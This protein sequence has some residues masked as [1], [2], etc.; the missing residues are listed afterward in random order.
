MRPIP[1]RLRLDLM[2]GLSEKRKLQRAVRCCRTAIFG[3]LL[4][5][6]VFAAPPPQPTF[7]LHDGELLDYVQRVLAASDET[8]AMREDLTLSQLSLQNEQQRFRTVVR[9]IANLAVDSSTRPRTGLEFSRHTRLGIDLSAGYATDGFGNGASARSFARLGI[10]L[11]QRFGRDINELPLTKAELQQRRRE[12]DYDR[13]LQHLIAD[14]VKNHIGLVLA[15]ELEQQAEYALSRAAKHT[16]AATARQRVGLISKVDVHRAEL[17]R[18]DREQAYELARYSSELKREE[19]AE[20]ARLQ[21]GSITPPENLP[22]L[23]LTPGPGFLPA[24]R[25]E[26]HIQRLDERSALLDLQASKRRMR[27]DL[28]LEVAWLG[29]DYGS[30]FESYARDQSDVYLSLRLDS[31][32]NFA[33][34][35]RAVA[36]QEIAYQRLRRN[37]RTLERRLAREVRQATANVETLARRLTL[38]AMRREEAEKAQKVSLVRFERGIASNLDVVD[39]EAALAEAELGELQAAAGHLSAIIELALARGELSLPWLQRALAEHDPGHQTQPV[40]TPLKQENHGYGERLA[41]N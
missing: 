3:V 31:D 39:A 13:R 32:L 1:R 22:A 12:L 5:A 28:K 23:S 14:A 7:S 36:A 11:F 16:Q 21:P 35:R 33:S 8:L 20:L 2:K 24:Q 25:A 10:P 34:K 37:G 19:Y 9:P 15:I 38:A 41:A 18:L 30:G 26:W 4:A 6:P 17:S 40:A 27:P 29:T